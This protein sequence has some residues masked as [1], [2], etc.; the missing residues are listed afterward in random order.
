MGNVFFIGTPG[1]TWLLGGRG[2][3]R[4]VRNRKVSGNRFGGNRFGGRRSIDGDRGGRRVGVGN[5]FF[6][7]TP[8]LTWLLGRKGSNRKVSNGKVSKSR[9]GGRGGIDGDRGGR[10]LGMGNV[11]FIGTP[12]L[13]WLLGR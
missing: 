13:T 5:I 3:N 11:F 4:K 7:R 1:L 12:G 8:G 2:S 9:F 10:R 6:I